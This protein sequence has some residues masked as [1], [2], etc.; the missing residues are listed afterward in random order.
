MVLWTRRLLGGG[1]IDPRGGLRL[2]EADS[3]GPIRAAVQCLAVKIAPGTREYNLGRESRA[4]AM[5]RDFIVCIQ[6]N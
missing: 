2:A 5:A 6:D 1:D 4:N 3:S